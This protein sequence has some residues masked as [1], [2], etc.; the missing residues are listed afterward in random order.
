LIIGFVLAPASWVRAQG[1]I[2]QETFSCSPGEVGAQLDGRAAEGD[3]SALWEATSGIGFA[4]TQSSV[5]NI[6]NTSQWESAGLPFLP[7]DYPGFASATV[8]A[9]VDPQTTS[10][11]VAIGFCSSAAAG[12][13][14]SGQVWMILYETGQVNVWADRSETLL[15]YANPAPGHVAGANQLKLKYNRVDKTVGVWVNG[16]QTFLGEIDPDNV[17]FDPNIT[18]VCLY[19]K[20]GGG[21]LPT[22]EYFEI[23]DLSVTLGDPIPELVVNEQP[24]STVFATEGVPIEL[25]CQA[26]G[27]V[28]PLAYRWQRV[29]NGELLSDGGDITGSLTS[30]L[31]VS[32]GS[33]LAGDSYRC[34]VTDSNS[35]ATVVYSEPALVEPGEVMILDTFTFSGSDRQSGLPLNGVLAEVGAA[36]E[37]TGNVVFDP[38]QHATADASGTYAAAGIA[39]NPGQNNVHR[40]LVLEAK[41]DPSQSDYIALG[42]NSSPT[43][44][45]WD[46]R[47]LQLTLR[48][49]GKVIFRAQDVVIHQSD[50]H[51]AFITGGLNQLNLEY[52][53]IS[54]TARAWLNGIELDPNFE[55]WPDGFVPTIDYVGFHAYPSGAYVTGQ[56]DVDDLI[57]MG[58]E[59]I[60]ELVAESSQSRDVT[61][62][63][64]TELI[65]SASGGI[66][67]YSYQ[68][69]WGATPESVADLTD[70]GMISGATSYRLQIWEMS[71]QLAGYYRCRATDSNLPTGSQTSSGTTLVELRSPLIA[72]R[73]INSDLRPVGD[74]LG[75]LISETGAAQWQATSTLLGF[76]AA[77]GGTNDDAI[78]SV[79]FDAA[80]HT[81]YARYLVEA[82][83]N[84]SQSGSGFIAVGFK[85]SALVPMWQQRQLVISLQPSG[86]VFVWAQDTDI[87]S[88][89][90]PHPA[91]KPEWNHVELEYDRLGNTARAWLN[92]VELSL[93]SFP[94]GFTPDIQYAG[95]HGNRVGGYPNNELIVDSFAASLVGKIIGHDTFTLNGTDRTE[96]AL[97]NGLPAEIGNRAWQA[98][99][100]ELDVDAA[101]GNA[102]GS[103][104]ATSA[105]ASIPVT[106]ADY[107]S[108]R[109]VR[110]ETMIDPTSSANAIVGFKGSAT[111]AM[112]SDRQL[113]ANLLSNGKLVVRAADFVLHQVIHPAFISGENHLAIEY[114]RVTNTAR[115]WLNRTEVDLDM[116]EWRLDGFVPSL[117]YA[118]FHGYVSTGYQPGE[119]VVDDFLV[120]VDGRIDPLS[121]A[122]HPKA[123]VK[124]DGEIAELSCVPDG[125]VPEYQYQWQREESGSYVPIGLSDPGFSGVDTSAL[126]ITTGAATAGWYRCHVTDS[127]GGSVDSNPAQLIL[128]PA[129]STGCAPY[130]PPLA[131]FTVNGGVDEWINNGLATWQEPPAGCGGGSCYADFHTSFSPAGDYYG[132]IERIEGAV[133]PVSYSTMSIELSHYDDGTTPLYLTLIWGASANERC[134]F[135][136][137]LSESNLVLEVDLGDKTV[138]PGWTSSPDFD[139]YY[140]RDLRIGFRTEYVGGGI[141]SI[142]MKPGPDLELPEAPYLK[143]ID[144]YLPGDFGAGTEMELYHEVHNAGCDMMVGD[145]AKQIDLRTINYSLCR[146]DGTTCVPERFQC[147]TPDNPYYPESYRGWVYG[148][149][150]A[151]DSLGDNEDFKPCTLTL[152]ESAGG[153]NLGKWY[154]KGAIEQYP[155]EVFPEREI[156]IVEEGTSGITIDEYYA[157]EAFDPSGTNRLGSLLLGQEFS[158]RL[159]VR[160]IMYPANEVTLR[161]YYRTFLPGEPRP[162]GFIALGDASL[163]IDFPLGTTELQLDDLR[164]DSIP[165]SNWA[166]VDLRVE[167][168]YRGNVENYILLQSWTTVS[169]GDVGPAV[170]N[171]HNI[172]ELS[173][174]FLNNDDDPCALTEDVFQ[175]SASCLVD[176]N[177]QWLELKLFRD[178]GSTT[179]SSRLL[180]GPTTSTDS[181][182]AVMVRYRRGTSYEGDP[183]YQLGAGWDA[184]PGEEIET[185]FDME[186]STY[187]VN[188]SIYFERYQW[189]VYLWTGPR[190][191]LSEYGEQ[192]PLASGSDPGSERS[193]A[194]ELEVSRDCPEGVSGDCTGYPR[195]YFDLMRVWKADLPEYDLRAEA[196]VNMETGEV[197]P[198]TVSRNVPIDIGLRVR[199]VGQFAVS[200]VSG[201][202]AG[203]LVFPGGEAFAIELAPGTQQTVSPEATADLDLI[204]TVNESSLWVPSQLGAHQFTIT[205]DVPLD[206]VES[207]DEVVHAVTVQE[208]QNDVMPVEIIDMVSGLKLESMQQG[209]E[210][211]IGLRVLNNGAAQITFAGEVE[212]LS[213]TDPGGVSEQLYLDT[214]PTQIDPG[215]TADINL[216]LAGKVSLWQPSQAGDYSFSVDLNHPGDEVPDND[217]LDPPQTVQVQ[218]SCDIQLVFPVA[219]TE[220]R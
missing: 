45:A 153:E 95:F 88:N 55:T 201:E 192:L 87:Y 73:F 177:N 215:A 119:L 188:T 131:D 52:D 219:I 2:Y 54:N 4:A 150:P 48:S 213:L 64:S 118:G 122:E 43:A 58:V 100:T 74:P 147:D 128:V 22:G 198:D 26:S 59:E 78:A 121:I 191:P 98:T 46:D 134:E 50:P 184:Y 24:Q 127:N 186:P 104:G 85:S 79:G 19:T 3:P 207:N 169:D 80:G 60:P 76:S 84:P 171:S 196:L 181:V 117:D 204:F 138:C 182:G 210:V 115:I 51:P 13:G 10:S 23:D 143:T 174:D 36:W 173:M 190:S 18:H 185:D 163:P 31:Q 90:N 101:D 29:S 25:S 113:Q 57:L 123:R 68:W 110:I 206:Q 157:V 62:G 178:A 39:V 216:E 20:Q 130:E 15:R 47:Q 106:S 162:A 11:S 205:L 125:G 91:F 166:L 41:V 148:D 97:L 77:A 217:L 195:H 8:E 111:G 160:A 176:V 142:V 203:T 71:E 56:L 21:G 187:T 69:Q 197:I 72:E 102:T 152:P 12:V 103:S 5:T 202:V 17:G 161:A 16:Q 193:V 151:G 183:P 89:I 75:G 35:P 63:M 44:N 200:V 42:F 146:A 33:L 99:Q 149:L 132:Q 136:E 164:I 107:S 70:G 28:A 1:L 167:L 6:A 82:W 158:L 165:T 135:T 92:G 66:A 86:R 67:P 159:Q 114:N 133:I 116:T 141:K 154:L 7:G 9:T 120:T 211:D 137:G 175:S 83:V 212:A 27:G 139:R 105:I 126:Q 81:D 155:D 49:N 108:W 172:S 214:T 189:K 30:T 32:D 14:S 129:Q 180:L 34:Q 179:G 194:V 96:G 144:H 199:N 145:V 65:C 93:N 40:R 170:S 156:V 37:A 61:D 140:I 53:R 38:D 109:R 124:E 94:A 112:W 218:A 209:A 220:T 208:I 168:E